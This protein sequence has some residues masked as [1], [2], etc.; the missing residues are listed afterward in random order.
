M[1]GFL[2]RRSTRKVTTGRLAEEPEE[3][4]GPT[5]RLWG[6]SGGDGV[7]FPCPDCGGPVGSMG[8]CHTYGFKEDGTGGL[9]CIGCWTAIY[10][11]CLG[12]PE[13]DADEGCG[14]SYTWGLNPKNPSSEGNDR[15]RPEWIPVGARWDGGW[16]AR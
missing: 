3:D 13:D 14:W 5:V 6:S 8:T 4:P 1:M 7:V 10:L 16:P 15:C 11:Y 2:F 9:A 12:D